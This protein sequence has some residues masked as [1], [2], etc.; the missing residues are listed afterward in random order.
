MSQLNRS[1]GPVGAVSIGLA[2]MIGAGLF[3]VWGPASAIAGAWLPAALVL[4]GVVA[5]VNALSTAQLAM[6]HPVS[7]GAYAYGR[8]EAKPWIGFSA[9]WMFVTGKTFS[10]AAIALVAARHIDQ[11]GAAAWAVIAL[12]ALAI[13][14]ILGI[15]LTSAI[16]TVIVVLVLAAVVFAL[17]WNAFGNESTLTQVSDSTSVVADSDSLM[18]A[19]GLGTVPALGVLQA[20]GILFFAF[21]GYA[22]MATLGEEVRDPRRTL[23]RAIVTALVIVLVL[24][25]L[26]AFAV[27]GTFRDRLPESMTPVADLVGHPVLHIVLLAAAVVACL[28]SLMGILAGLSRTSM[29]MARDGELPGVL[30]KINARTRTPVVAE[31]ACTCLAIIAV[32]TL[33][34]SGLVA[35][36][37]T[38]VLGYYAVAHFAA[39]RMRARLAD[40]GSG[41]RMWLPR[42]LPWFGLI[43]CLVIVLTLSWVG[44][45]AAIAW[46]GLGLLFRRTFASR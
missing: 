34:P 5:T 25:G 4:A 27:T 12:V 32:V 36:S 3:F 14:N 31:I 6:E 13:V 46:L 8:A 20:A 9:G 11:D 24:Y 45:V 21:A 15:R 37:S 38:F 26:V 40:A 22:R 44:V 2:A 16:S 42:W 7:G 10:A 43:S 17:V 35:F 1:I 33:P 39:I 41:P 30:G 28:G 18:A 23:P 29:A 19:F